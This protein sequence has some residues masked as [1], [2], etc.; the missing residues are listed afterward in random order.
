LHAADAGC[1]V[2]RALSSS[3][4]LESWFPAELIERVR[5]ALARCV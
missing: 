1:E 5:Q 3:I 2:L 4:D